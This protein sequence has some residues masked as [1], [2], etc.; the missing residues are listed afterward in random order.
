MHPIGIKLGSFVAV[1]SLP[2]RTWGVGKFA[3]ASGNMACVQYFDAP[4]APLPD[5]VECPVT[6]LKW[7]T[8]PTQT[9]VYRRHTAGRWQVGRVLHDENNEI[10]VQFPNNDRTTIDA[11]QLQV[12]WSRLLRDP[13]PLL[14]VEATET[15]F[16]A[17]ARSEFVR[18]VSR[19]RTAS[20]GVT[21]VLS[22]SI[23]LVDYQFEVVRRV[24]TDPVQR[25]LLADEVGLGKTIE[26]GI[27]IRQYFL[28][29]PEL[30]RVVVV[31][32]TTLVQQWRSELSVRFGLDGLLDHRLHVVEHDNLDV[33]NAAFE[34]GAGML[35]V[36]EAHHLSHRGSATRD[37]LYAMLQAHARM[38]P[39]LLLLSATPV[40]GDEAGFLRL[41]HLLD[42]VVFPLDDVEG[43]RRRIASRQVVAE[44]VAMLTPE[45]Q[46]SLEPELDRLEEA[47]GDDQ[48]LMEKVSA[49]RAVLET[50]PDEEDETFIAVL[51]DLRVH[52]VETYR[53][54][55][56]LLRNRRALVTWAT[57]RRSGLK[58][59][60]LR[61][62]G[63]Q[64]WSELLDQLRLQLNSVAT[65]SSNLAA[66]LLCAAVHPRSGASLHGQ[67][68][69][70]GVK[71]AQALALAQ[72]L[73]AAG[74]KLR[75][76][77]ARFEALVAL[78]QGL[79]QTPGV[80][81]VVF[82]DQCSDAVQAAQ[83]LERMLPGRV[84][85][86]EPD[87]LS[88]DTEDDAASAPWRRFLSAPEQIRVLVCDARAEEGVNLHGGKKVAVHFD[89]PPAPNRIEQ[90]LGRLDRY[91]TGDPIAS[92]VLVDEGLPDEAAWLH[93][94]DA[95]WRVFH[96][97]VASLQ[98]L[99]ESTVRSLG[100]EWMD[101]GT[102][103]LWDH[104]Q[105]LA[106]DDGLVQ[107]ELHQ[108]NLQDALDAQGEVPE[109]A[110][111][112]LEES[113]DDWQAWRDAFKRFAVDMLSF[114]Q[115]C[116]ASVSAQAADPVFRIAYVPNDRGRPTLITLPEY[117][118]VFLKSVDRT[119]ST[120]RAPMTHPYAFRRQNAV[121]RTALAQRVHPLRVGDPLVTALERMCEQDDRGRAFAM[122]RVDRQYVVNNACGADLF[123]RF[124]FVVRPRLP[125]AELDKA[126]D[127][128]S[129]ARKA[130]ALMSP[131]AVRIWV[132]GSGAIV[133]EPPPL[134][135]A[136][137]CHT[138]EGTR[139]DFN[140][141]P[142]RWRQLP[143][144][145]QSAWMR[146]WPAL[147]GQRRGDAEAA[148]LASAAF[149]DHV[150][151]ALKACADEARM[152]RAQAASRLVRLE[153]A[154][155]E[156][157]Q[158]EL[159]RDEAL[160]IAL[161]AALSEPQMLLD[162]VGAVFAADDTPFQA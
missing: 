142:Q 144:Q 80:Q 3:S 27:I 17:D 25:Y 136:R 67:L 10:L 66:N 162:V 104:A 161:Q 44:V 14:A 127:T 107:R 134:L 78:V 145:V 116:Q 158:Q 63:A 123:F 60:Q 122:W 70:A 74:R 94:L 151:K 111:D 26:A 129:F 43:L 81:V 92:H 138:W 41:L 35:V 149:R 59:V 131:L 45:N 98:Y 64:R 105:Q 83:L 79:L 31:V 117:L 33:L 39:R 82:C 97:S 91:G 9:R 159:D 156:R 47:Y 23:E 114:E 160:Y 21:A 28:D 152:R 125:G 141:N 68:H 106:G 96:R 135:T 147:C 52:L 12:R 109:T 100:Q 58:A 121:S 57:P 87:M 40:L 53:L 143:L 55:R 95:G 65:P 18:Q 128:H 48:L 86:H 36:D 30:A 140:L 38:T 126:V 75:A 154:A 2:Y 153:G 71:D 73:D 42:P 84:S 148:V 90:R 115:V 34:A 20:A 139:R 113:D 132:D 8:L 89:L 76:D 15:P 146:D 37:R 46:W 120:S 137:Y 155:R 62:Q 5:I 85:R 16:M 101:Q 4:G 133:D 50:F 54:H 7:V 102:Q 49:L 99:I 124:D 119:H 13:L 72:E 112:E 157:E 29:E 88:S 24:L 93:V 108:I 32:P 110:L 51:A 22:S 69:A 77:P 118:R 150:S 61:S 103:A 6:S 11:E 1:N 19:Q 56:R 130:G